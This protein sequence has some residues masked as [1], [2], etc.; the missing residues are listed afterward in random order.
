MAKAVFAFLRMP[1]HVAAKRQFNIH[2]L[3]SLS[4][5]CLQPFYLPEYFRHMFIR[6]SKGKPVSVCLPVQYFVEILK[7]RL[8]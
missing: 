8:L 4:H 2:R 1:L 7:T 3:S 5:L 6:K